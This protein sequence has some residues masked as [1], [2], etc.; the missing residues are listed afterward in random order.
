[1]SANL[2]WI[3]FILARFAMKGGQ[4]QDPKLMTRGCPGLATLS[5]GTLSPVTGWC[6][7]GLGAGLYSEANCRNTVRDAELYRVV[8][9]IRALQLSFTVLLYGTIQD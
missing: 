5:R 3:S 8:S 7:A 9:S 2:A 1:M 4:V 6:R